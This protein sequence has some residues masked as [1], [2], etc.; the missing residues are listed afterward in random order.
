MSVRTWA[1][2][3]AGV[4]A[5][6]LVAGCG[7]GGAGE[8]GEDGDSGEA[9]GESLVVW[10]PGKSESEMALINDT[11]VPAFEEETGAQV[12]VTFVDWPDLSP[13]LSAAFAA[14]TAPDVI[15]HGVAATADLAANERVLDLSSYIDEM[16]PE[17]RDDI[18]VA[19]EGGEVGGT[20]YMVPLIMT[21]RMLVY[22]GAD[23]TEAGLDPEAPPATWEEVHEVAEQLTV[24]DGDQI[25]RSGL[26]LGSQPIA[27]QQSF[28]TLLWSNGGDFLNE[29]D[30]EA[31]MN[32]PEGVEALQ[33]FVD[34]YQGENPVDGMLGV[35]WSA[36]PVGE[37][38][39]IAG[40]ASMQLVSAGAIVDYQAAAPDRD[41]R[42]MPPPAFE[43][44]EP[45]TFGGP[46]NGLMI[47]A[48]SEVPDLAWEFIASMVEPETNLTYAQ[49]LG[50]LPIHASAIESDYIT[51]N[52]ELVTA[53]EALPYTSGNPNVPG[54]VQMRDAMGQHLERAL[55]GEAD[56]ADALDQ[57]A[58]E[59]DEIIASGS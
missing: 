36:L 32:S 57:S 40:T 24:R 50:Q 43:G 29:D 5:V 27:N 6:S 3:V 47:N 14:G 28:A 7:S 13:K 39:V 59:V 19:L 22:S 37:Q 38:P 2:I 58:S 12:E 20:P 11:I 10:F 34:L 4:A 23:F 16:D 17:L 56:P 53:V 52:P 46:G 18:S 42:L 9:S 51:S 21:A 48:D 49:E 8:S 35:E 41:L 25:T 44:S 33:Y 55:H 31:V 45:G 26:L 15:G 30:T 54:W 1:G